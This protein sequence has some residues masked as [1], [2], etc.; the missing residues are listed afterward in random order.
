M[1][2]YRNLRFAHQLHIAI[3]HSTLPG[4]S[5]TL[6]SGPFLCLH[7]P[8]LVASLTASP[9]CS[10]LLLYDYPSTPV[11]SHLVRCVL[12]FSAPSAL[13]ALFAYS[14]LPHTCTVASVSRTCTLPSVSRACTLARSCATV[15]VL[16]GASRPPVCNRPLPLT[17]RL[18]GTVGR[19]DVTWTC[20]TLARA[21]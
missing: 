20:A 2:L 4:S 3:S 16:P 12:V 21:A 9:T 8:D 10:D 6:F 7:F 18:R 19:L 15:R 1:W 17:N 14:V 13:C 5:L 11:P